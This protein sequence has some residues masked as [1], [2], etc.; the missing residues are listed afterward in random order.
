MAARFGLDDTSMFAFD[1]R[2][3]AWKNPADDM[4]LKS[5]TILRNQLG[6]VAKLNRL[7]P[8]GTPSAPKLDDN[9]GAVRR[10]S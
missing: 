3:D 4:W 9:G 1:G 8:D 6:A 5:Y 2:L 7:P 10:G